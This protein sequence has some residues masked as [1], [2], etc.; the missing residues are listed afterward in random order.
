MKNKQWITIG[1]ATLGMT[2]LLGT[3]GADPINEEQAAKIATTSYPGKVVRVTSEDSTEGRKQFA[4]EVQSGIYDRKVMV[5]AEDGNVDMI[6]YRVSGR[7]AWIA[8]KVPMLTP[9]NTTNQ[10]PRP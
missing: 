2:M 10:Q 6:Y 8:K 9:R 4:V 3:A 1:L 7:T 5:D